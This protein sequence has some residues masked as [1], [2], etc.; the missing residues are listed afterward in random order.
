[1]LIYILQ[2]I[3][4]KL[5]EKNAAIECPDGTGDFSFFVKMHSFLFEIHT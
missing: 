4:T 5:R 2:G 3:S 1:M